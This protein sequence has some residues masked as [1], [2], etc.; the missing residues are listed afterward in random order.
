M[1][2]LKIFFVL[3]LG[4]INGLASATLITSFEGGNTLAD[5]GLTLTQGIPSRA[6]IQSSVTSLG[7]TL[8]STHG[9]HLFKLIGGTSADIINPAFPND[10]TTL[11]TFNNPVTIDKPYLLLDFAFMNRDVSPTNDR[12]LIGLNGV[13]YDLTGSSETGWHEP[14]TL[15]WQTLAVHFTSLG[16]VNFSFGCVNKTYNGGSSYCIGDYLRTADVI[17]TLAQNNGIPIFSSP[18]IPNISLAPPVTPIPEPSTWAL[19]LFGLLALVVYWWPRRDHQPL[20]VA[21]SFT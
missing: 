19:M 13:L 18:N 4:M 10:L 3:V 16:S 14:F 1:K 11:V 8:S 2:S 9:D 21:G 7:T 20:A 6:T 17:P 15:G 12:M 5:N